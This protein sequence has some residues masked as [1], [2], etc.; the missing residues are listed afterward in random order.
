M[1]AEPHR[2]RIAPRLDPDALSADLL[3]FLKLLDGALQDLA[4]GEGAPPGFDPR[5]FLAPGLPRVRPLLV[6]LSARA[7]GDGASDGAELRDP[8]TQHVA[9][10]AELLHI[11]IA[12][13]DAA[14]GRQGGRRRRAARRL[15]GGA[16]GM[17]AGHHLTLRALELAR[18]TH[19]P[20]IVGDLLETMREVAEGHALS[21]RLRQ[22][23]ATSEEA[24]ALAEGHSGAVFSFACRAGGRLAHA[25]RSVV[26]ALGRYGR[27]TG[28]AW[29]IAEELA[30]IDLSAGEDPTPFEDRAAEGRP[31]FTISVAA[32]RDPGLAAAWTAFG[33]RRPKPD[34]ALSLAER[35]RAAGGFRV[36]RARLARESWAAQQA[37]IGLE[38]S[39]HRQAL[40]ELAAALAR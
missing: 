28:I 25:D 40:G 27:H 26:S 12:L 17:L 24:L 6:L 2:R 10:A 35:I 31:S 30:W 36:G 29:Y 39:P 9:A 4:G 22:R 11:A 38:P 14:L 33:R 5:L 34:E 8:S 15:I 16:V 20:E 32:E 3:E 21:E 19:A 7:A 1:S 13:H 23:F 37:L 18:H